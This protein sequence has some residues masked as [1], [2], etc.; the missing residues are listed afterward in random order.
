MALKDNIMADLKQAMKDKDQDK[1]R[2]L[3]SLKAKILEKEIGPLRLYTGGLTVYTTLSGRLQSVGRLS[4]PRDV[5][6][7]QKWPT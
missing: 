7:S 4:A 2:V 5:A 3:R 1:L 6:L